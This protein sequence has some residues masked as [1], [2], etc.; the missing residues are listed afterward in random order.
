MA[1]TLFALSATVFSA[2]TPQITNILGSI[3][4]PSAGNDNVFKGNGNENGNNNGD[5]NGNG[6][7]AGVR[8]SHPT[9]L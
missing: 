5:D 7:S 9:P 6:N 3:T 8:I 2:P 4:N 1:L